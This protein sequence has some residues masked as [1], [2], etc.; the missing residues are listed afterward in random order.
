MARLFLKTLNGT[1]KNRNVDKYRIKWNGKSLSKMQF[2]VKQFLKKYWIGHAVYEEFPVFGTRLRV[3]ILNLTK[4]IAIEVNGPQHGE[5]NEFFHKG[6]RENYRK[7]IARDIEKYQWLKLNNFDL[8]E[9]EEK[10]IKRLSKEY[11][12]E[13]FG[14][15]IV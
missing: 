10:D 15:P 7:S 11:I 4:N 1:V 2:N 6:N 3:D 9:L 8:I 14:I 12:E 5:Y 13:T